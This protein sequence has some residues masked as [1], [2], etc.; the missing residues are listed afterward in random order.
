[1]II[2][3]IVHIINCPFL[4]ALSFLVAMAMLTAFDF[5]L[6]KIDSA[7]ILIVPD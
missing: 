5:S 6:L 4:N 2:I 1:M 7:T 3:H